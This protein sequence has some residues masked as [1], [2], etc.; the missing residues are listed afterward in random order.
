[1]YMA[2]FAYEEGMKPIDFLAHLHFSAE[3]LLL[4]PGVASTCK[5]LS[6][7]VFLCAFL[8]GLIR[9]YLFIH[10]HDFIPWIAPLGSDFC[11][12]MEC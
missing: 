9:V 2:C 12:L 4:Y 1:M 5:M 8:I 7:S 3:E 11:A 10:K 6:V